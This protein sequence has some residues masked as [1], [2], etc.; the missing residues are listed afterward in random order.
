MPASRLQEVEG[1]AEQWLLRGCGGFRSESE[2]HQVSSYI[3][4]FF[5]YNIHSNHTAV[6][7]LLGVAP[8]APVDFGGVVLIVFRSSS[9]MGRQRLSALAM[10][11]PRTLYLHWLFSFVT[12][13]QTIRPYI[14]KYG[15]Y[16]NLQHNIMPQVPSETFTAWTARLHISWTCHI[17]LAMT[18]L[19][20]F[21]LTFI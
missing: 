15:I 6:V 7:F 3:R 11:A 12:S 9:L 17:N 5:D 20:W 13:H 1:K 19:K 14:N 16:W 18:W 10:K 4:T 8:T 21:F 2:G